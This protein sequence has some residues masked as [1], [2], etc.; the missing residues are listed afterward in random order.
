MEELGKCKEEEKEYCGCWI[1]SHSNHFLMASWELAAV[2]LI[3]TSF[4]SIIY[5]V[6]ERCFAKHGNS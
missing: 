5:E 4:K 6:A 1:S 2:T 3:N